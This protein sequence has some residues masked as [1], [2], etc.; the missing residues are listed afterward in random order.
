[1]YCVFFSF[2]FWISFRSV[3]EHALLCFCFSYIWYWPS[4]TLLMSC[5][6]IMNILLRHLMLVLAK[7]LGASECWFVQLRLNN[8]DYHFCVR[9]CVLFRYEK[10]RVLL[11]LHPDIS[12]DSW[13]DDKIQLLANLPVCRCLSCMTFCGRREDHWGVLFDFPSTPSSANEHKSSG[14]I[15]YFVYITATSGNFVFLPQEILVAFLAKETSCSRVA[16]LSLIISPWCW[17]NICIIMAGQFL[18]AASDLYDL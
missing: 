9:Q 13:Q 18:S 17:Q 5:F 12:L 10:I 16:L 8:H 11:F 6:Y 4:F 7:Y 3:W 2:F 14:P 15:F 1:M